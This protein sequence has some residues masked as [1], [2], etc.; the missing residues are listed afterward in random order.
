VP[1]IPATVDSLTAAVQPMVD[2]IAACGQAMFD[3]FAT[4]VETMLGAVA[5]TFQACCATFVPERGLVP[6]APVQARFDAVAASRHAPFDAL[7]ASIHAVLDAVATAVQSMFDA[8]AAVGGRC[9]AGRKQQQGAGQRRGKQTCHAILLP[10]PT[11]AGR[12]TPPMRG[13]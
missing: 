13:G 7:A 11:P 1:T 2:A 10:G 4:A 3:A 6:G 8:V 9:R 5:A 12:T